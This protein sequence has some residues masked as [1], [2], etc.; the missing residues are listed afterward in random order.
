MTSL[1]ERRSRAETLA[2]CSDG[3]DS[4]PGG[5][6]HF[7]EE[8]MRVIQGFKAPLLNPKPEYPWIKTPKQMEAL[9]L[10]LPHFLQGH[11]HRWPGQAHAL[12]RAPLFHPRGQK[13]SRHFR[14]EGSYLRGPHAQ[15]PSYDRPLRINSLVRVALREQLIEGGMF[16]PE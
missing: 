9:C 2:N 7:P 1:A 4:V 11:G 6:D 5:R 16:P 8:R 3:G 10:R 14:W 15:R 12:A 13:W